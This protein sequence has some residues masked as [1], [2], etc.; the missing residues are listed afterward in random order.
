M[1]QTT[2]MDSIGLRPIRRHLREKNAQCASPLLERAVSFAFNC[3]IVR[4]DFGERNDFYACD[5]GE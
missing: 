4:R 2:G 5:S 1:L 3:R